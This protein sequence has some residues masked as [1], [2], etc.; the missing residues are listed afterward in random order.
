MTSVVIPALNEA[1]NIEYVAGLA[2]ASPCV[3]EIIV[4]DDGSIDETPDSS[5]RAGA[6]VVTSTLL[7][8]GA[9]M[10]DGLRESRG[11]VIVYLDGDLRGLDRGF[12]ERLVEPIRDGR[13]DFA[14]ARFSRS[15]GR[16]TTLTAKPLLETFFPELA[17]FA[18]PLGGIVA[19]RRNL[20]ERLSFEADYGVDLALLIDAHFAGARMIEV[21]IG[22]LEHDSQT[23]EALGD[24]A[25]QVVRALLHRAERHGRLSIGQVHEVEEVERQA[26]AE[27]TRVAGRM[28]GVERLALFDMDG[29]LLRDRSVLEL[30]RRTGRLRQV[31][32]YLDNPA[33]TATGRTRRIAECLAGVPRADFVEVARSM[34]LSEGAAETIIALRKRGYRVGIVSDSFRIVTEVVRRRVFADFSV[35]NLLRFR[36]GAATGDVQ[37]SPLFQH[38]NGC[39]DH[40][41][42]KWNALLHIEEKLAIPAERVLAVGDGANDICLLREAGLGIAFEPKTAE[43]ERAADRV[44]RGDLRQ[45][46]LGCPGEI[47]AA[48]A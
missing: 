15:A 16:V 14:K 47:M 46:L 13:A 48:A 6:R 33:F 21:D 10:E 17:H 41:V 45:V 7:G 28:G 43:L 22:H 18:Q 39:R 37:L 29:T 44:I 4:I 23:L 30:A 8:K 3:G 2:A 26:N 35:A 32:E 31:S 20:L 36:A 42:C 27:F 9:S 34:P 25:K 5:R 38:G 40:E 24:M 11:D 19:V 12:L 1:K